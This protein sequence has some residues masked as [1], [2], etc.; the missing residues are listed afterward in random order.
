MT[1]IFTWVCVS[2]W[3]GLLA[4]TGYYSAMLPKHYLMGNIDVV[5][6]IVHHQHILYAWSLAGLGVALVGLKVDRW[7]IPATIASSL[8]YLVGWYIRGP[9]LMVGPVDGFRLMWQTAI[10]LGTYAQFI[11]RDVLAPAA[12]VVALVG[13]LLSLWRQKSIASIAGR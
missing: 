10:T 2:A 5:P 6:E 13:A 8:T 11:V 9:M 3:A 12:F 7:W 1:R 4:F